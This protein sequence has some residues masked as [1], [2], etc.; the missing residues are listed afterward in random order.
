MT[1]KEYAIIGAITL[2]TSIIGC[3]IAVAYVAPALA[4]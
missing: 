2:A 1:G 3:T 4:K